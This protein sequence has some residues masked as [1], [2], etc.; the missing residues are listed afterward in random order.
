[1]RMSNHPWWESR[2]GKHGWWNPGFDE[3]PDEYN[4]Y[5]YFCR[6]GTVW[7][8]GPGKEFDWWQMTEG[9]VPP[10]RPRPR[11]STALT[12]QRAAGRV[13]GSRN[14]SEVHQ[15]PYIRTISAL[16]LESPL[17]SQLRIPKEDR[18][19]TAR[20]VPA[21]SL[22]WRPPL[23]TLRPPVQA[24]PPPKT[25]QT[26]PAE[27]IAG[28]PSPLRWFH[29]LSDLSPGSEE[30]ELFLCRRCGFVAPEYDWHQERGPHGF[31]HRFRCR[32]CN[33]RYE[34]W[35]KDGRLCKF[36]KV[37]LNQDPADETKFIA[38]P[39]WWTEL[40]EKLFVNLFKEIT[41]KIRSGSAE[42]KQVTYDKVTNIISQ[43]VYGS[44]GQPTIF[45][46]VQVP[47]SVEK[48]I[49]TL[50][51]CKGYEHCDT[52]PQDIEGFFFKNHMAVTEEEIFTD[53]EVLCNE[54][55]SCFKMDKV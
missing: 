49:A 37:L 13:L 47:A 30:K 39:A 24:S 5:W 25:S 2:D 51:A 40:S 6:N 35:R 42:M 4:V 44:Y 8:K 14:L 55:A 1:M 36:N 41:L 12:Y 27:A 16:A 50:S 31:L 52:S 28:K 9:R 53:F 29:F 18:P 11:P 22:G 26:K 23:E 54:I 19:G 46:M 21:T 17:G 48:H 32:R 45:E 3:I 38:T 43:K 33:A 7:S 34:P 15:N 20:H 10:W